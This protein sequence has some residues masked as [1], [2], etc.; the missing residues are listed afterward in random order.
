MRLRLWLDR[1]CCCCIK[2]MAWLLCHSYFRISSK[3]RQHIPGHGPFLIACHHSSYLDP[4]SIGVVMPGFISY[5]AREDIFR[6]PLKWVIEHLFVYPISR[7][8]GDIKAL[9]IAQDLLKKG[10]RVL[11]FPEGTRSD[12]GRVKTFKAGV[13]LIA[14]RTQVPVLPVYIRGA[15]DCW[16]RSRRLPLP[17]RI[18]V[19]FG[20][21]LMPEDFRN[22]PRN[23]EGFARI[24]NE[25]EGRVKNLEKEADL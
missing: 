5:L 3:G 2:S 21:P 8:S 11:L 19:F 24:A 16:P 6:P 14:L 23:R 25:L 4:V 1:A 20:P 9:R 17:G 15:Y 13:G 12:T 18:R 22:Q 7:D 10:H